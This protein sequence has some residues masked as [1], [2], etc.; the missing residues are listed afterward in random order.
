MGPAP[1]E[2]RITFSPSCLGRAAIL[3]E[4]ALPPRKPSARSPTVPWL[5]ESWPRGEKGAPIVYR[6]IGG[7]GWATVLDCPTLALDKTRE[8]HK[9]ETKVNFSVWGRGTRVQNRRS[10]VRWATSRHLSGDARA[11]CVL[12]RRPLNREK[13]NAPWHGKPCY[14]VQRR[15]HGNVRADPWPEIPTWA[16]SPEAGSLD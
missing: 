8:K 4:H 1:R 11:G 9:I 14:G 6:R 16:R 5:V 3:C 13:S 2:V 7:P 15:Q 12:C 10:G